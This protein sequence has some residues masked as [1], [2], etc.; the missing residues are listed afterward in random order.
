MYCVSC[1]SAIYQF[2]PS[3][4][5]SVSISITFAQKVNIKLLVTNKS[6][7]KIES[8]TSSLCF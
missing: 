3:D 5:E 2:P 8:N 1:H 6:V 7:N 4:I